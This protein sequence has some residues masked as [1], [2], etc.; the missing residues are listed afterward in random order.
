MQREWKFH[1]IATYMH[2]YPLSVSPVS[3]KICRNN[4][5]LFPRNK[6]PNASFVLRRFVCS[7]WMKAE[8]EGRGEGEDEQ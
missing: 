1:T 5:Q 7:D 2:V 4:N 8:F 3:I 6:V